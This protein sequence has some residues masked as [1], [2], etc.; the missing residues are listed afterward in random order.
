MK[1]PQYIATISALAVIA[2]IAVALSAFLLFQ[3]QETDN[4]WLFDDGGA[5][6]YTIIYG[7][8][9]TKSAAELLSNELSS[10]TGASFDTYEDVQDQQGKEIRIGLTSRSDSSYIELAN[11]IGTNGYKISFAQDGSIDL[12][13]FADSSAKDAVLCFIEKYLV[14]DM[15]GRFF[16]YTDLGYT[17]VEKGGSEPDTSLTAT[18]HTLRFNESNSFKILIF[19]DIH[20]G[21]DL[22]ATTA[23]A[24]E[25]MVDKEMPDLVLLAGNI[26]DK[27]TDKASLRELLEKVS[28][29]METRGIAWAH[30]FGPEDAASGMSLDLQM[31][32]YAEFEYCISKKGALSVDGVSNYF[33]PILSSASDEIKFGIWALDSALT[34]PDKSYGYITPSQVSWFLSE[35]SHIT[36]QADRAIPG[37]MFMCNPLP[38]FAALADS[39]NIKGTFGEAVSIALPNPGLFSAALSTKS[40]LGIYAGYDH[41]NDFSGD[42]Y[43][44]E[45]GYLSSIGYDGY[46]LGGTFDTN[47]SLRGARLIEINENDIKNYTSKMIYAAD[48]GISREANK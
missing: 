33:L 29:P 31:E 32:V 18:K 22:N 39:G 1:K 23:D 6:S 7:K 12:V 17:S 21:N 28:A 41:L 48:Y 11:E 43:G 47:N 16:F 26:Q 44:I 15:D 38:E 5:P 40:I 34:S 2:L 8:D 19:S 4:A 37:I 35:Y 9:Y 14:K 3:A 45:L 10:L 13:A 20:S 25:A 42:Y 36:K 24:I 27:L 46:G 30:V